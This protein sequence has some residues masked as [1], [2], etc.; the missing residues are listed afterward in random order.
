LQRQNTDA[1]LLRPS[2]AHLDSLGPPAEHLLGLLLGHD[3][4]EGSAAGCVDGAELVKALPDTNS[5]AGGNGG[6]ESGG[7][8]HL[9]ADDWNADQVGLGLRVMLARYFHVEGMWWM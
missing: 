5:E 9:W 8:A 2:P 3:R 4:L 6:T 7:L 1:H